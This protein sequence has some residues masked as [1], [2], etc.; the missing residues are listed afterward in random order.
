VSESAYTLFDKLIYP[1][2]KNSRVYCRDD[3]F[4][5]SCQAQT[6]RQGEALRATFGSPQHHRRQPFE[7]LH[8]DRQGLI[9]VVF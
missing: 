5:R 1:S 9:K 2:Q 7:S 4:Q 3:G 8:R 6:F